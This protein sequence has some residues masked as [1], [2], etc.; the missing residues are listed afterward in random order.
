MEP[1]VDLALVVELLVF[2][3]DILEF[4]SYLLLSFKVLSLPNL[5]EGS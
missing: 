4:N 5:A 1:Q 2:G 3:V